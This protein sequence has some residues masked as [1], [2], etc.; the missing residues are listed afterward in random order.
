MR[1]LKKVVRKEKRYEEEK[2]WC[3]EKK[4][5]VSRKMKSFEKIK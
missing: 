5:G 1:K 2:E 4:I 3:E